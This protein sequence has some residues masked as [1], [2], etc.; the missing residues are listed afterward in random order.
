TSAAVLEQIGLEQKADCA[1]EFKVVLDDIGIPRSGGRVA[2]FALLPEHRAEQMIAADL[3]V[4]GNYGGGASAEQ[5]VLSGGLGKVVV[6]L[7]GG[8]GLAAPAP[9]DA[10]RIGTLPSA[11]DAIQSADVGVD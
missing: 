4:G 3:D 10:G 7:Q 8:N 11:G 9:A 5:N 2:G 6:N 1:L